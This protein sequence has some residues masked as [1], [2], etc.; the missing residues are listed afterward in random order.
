M[1][2]LHTAD[3]SGARA[4]S[5]AQ[6][7][8]ARIALL[9]LM[10]VMA[11]AAYCGGH[12]LISGGVVDPLLSLTWAAGMVAPWVVCWLVLRRAA[13]RS[14]TEGMLGWSTILGSLVLAAGGSAG[15]ERVAAFL[16]GVEHGPAFAEL[17]FRKLPA[18]TGFALLARHSLRDLRGHAR[19]RER[20]SG[21][22]GERPA[23]AAIRSGPIDIRSEVRPE[24][25]WVRAA[26]NY[27]ELHAGGHCDLVRKTLTRFAA[28][29]E[30]RFLRIHRSVLV[31]RDRI[32]ALEQRP[33]GR[34]VV[35]LQDGCT[36]PIG[37]GF[38]AEVE[39]IL[40]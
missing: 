36:L 4:S 12:T 30:D 3:G 16:F 35:R 22:G 8:P 10:V 21:P 19:E 11:C 34:L 7:S 24:I 27:L 14:A 39:R 20:A 38:R 6:A 17:V 40:G 13:Q 33:R 23:E 15:W 2:A 5:L 26:G 9:A 25:E 37:R 28:E 32:A 31:R 1:T 18:V 29:S